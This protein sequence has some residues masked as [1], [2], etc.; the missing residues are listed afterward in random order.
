M[1]RV[2]GSFRSTYLHKVDGK[3][4]VSVPAAFR[5]VLTAGDPDASKEAGIQPRTVL[6]RSGVET[7][8]IRG[9]TMAGIAALED[10]A[11]SL[12]DYDMMEIFEEE[13]SANSVEVQLDDNGRLLLGRDLRESLGIGEEAEFV[14][15]LD[16]FEI[17]EPGTR[18][19]WKA[20]LQADEGAAA[21][22]REMMRKLMSVPVARPGGGA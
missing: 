12:G 15:K 14:G 20:A 9:Y 17:W 4:R 8:F 6:V 2:A 3:G 16:R 7:P 22:R 5:E 11:R 18:A 19:G 13:Y 1:E 10:Q 21:R